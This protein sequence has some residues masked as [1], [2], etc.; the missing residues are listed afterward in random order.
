M[1]S[2]GKDDDPWSALFRKKGEHILFCASMDSIITNVKYIEDLFL[3]YLG[4]QRAVMASQAQ[5]TNQTFF[6]QFQCRIES[7]LVGSFPERAE[8]QNIGVMQLKFFQSAFETFGN[9]LCPGPIVLHHHYHSS[10][11]FLNQTPYTLCHHPSSERSPVKIVDPLIKGFFY[12]TR[13]SAV[14]GTQPQSPHL[15]PGPS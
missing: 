11:V 15:Q 7:S 13:G 6:S 9:K 12:C 14:G 4:K 2:G 3:L 5:M 1:A 10:S 8:K